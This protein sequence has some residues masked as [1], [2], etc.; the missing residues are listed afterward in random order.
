MYETEA[1]AIRFTID[2]YEPKTA[3]RD[4]QDEYTNLMWACDVCNMRKGNRCPPDNARQQGYRFFRPDQDVREEHFRASGI[5]IEPNSNIG[6]FTIEAVDLNRETLRRL[7]QIREKLFK[8]ASLVGEGIMA[9]RRMKIDQLPRQIRGRAIVAMRRMER[10]ADKFDNDI[11][12]LLRSFARS[13][14]IDPE[15]D[16]NAE[17][18]AKD[19]M[20][21][22]EKLQGLF[23]GRWRPSR[24]K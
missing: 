10:V 16:A 13:A 5:R 14:L 1:H 21:K 12:N 4:L 24:K 8:E 9:L 22:L 7:R 11:D 20:E 18:R 17:R 15:E 6:Y 2:H 3:R 23:P 19:R